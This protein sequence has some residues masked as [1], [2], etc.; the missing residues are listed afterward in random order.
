MIDL[1]TGLSS[2]G[3]ITA[4]L[5]QREKTGKGTK[6]EC[7]LLET[8]VEMVLPELITSRRFDSAVITLPYRCE[9]FE[10]RL[11]IETSWNSS[12]I[13]C[14]LPSVCLSRWWTSGGGSSE[15]SIFQGT[16]LSSFSVGRRFRKFW[17]CSRSS[18]CLSWWRMICIERIKSEWKIG[19]C[20]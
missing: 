3:A 20:S 17:R 1:A 10:C 7:S 8:Q 16:L 19:R 5:Y 4:A 18:E 15:R 9:L 2:V 14:P 11:G 13:D 6:I 12:S